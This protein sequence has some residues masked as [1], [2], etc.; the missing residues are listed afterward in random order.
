MKHEIGPIERRLR[1]VSGV[2]LLALLFGLYGNA[3]W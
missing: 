1:N 3:R 2:L